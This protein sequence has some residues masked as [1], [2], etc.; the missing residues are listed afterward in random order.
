[1]YFVCAEYDINKPSH[2]SLTIRDEDSNTDPLASYISEGRSFR[3]VK[4]QACD[5]FGV[6]QDVFSVTTVLSLP[7]YFGNKL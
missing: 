5:R 4:R 2:L 1:M 7:R 3:D 6:I